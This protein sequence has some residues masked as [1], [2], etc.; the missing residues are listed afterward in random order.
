MY[1]PAILNILPTNIL[2]TMDN[3]KDSKNL[4][5]VSGT[6]ILILIVLLVLKIRG[7]RNE[8]A[9]NNA[10]NP[11]ALE[12][13]EDVTTGSVNTKP[14]VA[15]MSYQ[16][17]LA[18]YADRRIQL[19]DAC[20]ATPANMT[21]KN[22]TDIMIDNRS[23]LGRTLKVGGAMTVKGYGFKI[24]KVKTGDTLPVTWL[25]DC[26]TSQNVATILIQK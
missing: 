12:V 22:D 11:D 17:A 1:V 16:A 9:D 14:P 19:N 6:I 23:A 2:N 7:S 24:V 4:W 15:P 18:K 26:D 3:Q 5:I 21:F 8:T 20:Q 13:T 25:I 10:N